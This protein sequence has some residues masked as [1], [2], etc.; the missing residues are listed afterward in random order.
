MQKQS[1]LKPQTKQLEPKTLTQTKEINLPSQILENRW[2]NQTTNTNQALTN[3]VNLKNH[4]YE[5]KTNTKNSLYMTLV[6]TGRKLSKKLLNLSKKLL[7][8]WER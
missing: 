7:E 6:T 2:Q 8:K 3:Q 5:P 4:K 1:M